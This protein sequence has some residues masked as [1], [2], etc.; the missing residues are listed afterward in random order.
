L[1]LSISIAMSDFKDVLEKVEALHQSLFPEETFKWYWLDEK[2]ERQYTN[3]K[4]AKNQ[5]TFFTVL[6]IGI[7]CLGLLGLITNK[8]VEK[9]KEIGIRKVMGAQLYQIAE[10]L[11]NTTVKQILIATIIGIPLAYFL[12]QKYLEKFSER[13][14]LQW[15]YFTVPVII[16]MMIMLATV[17]SVLWKAAKSNPV[18]ALKYE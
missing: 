17:A 5:I 18:E 16:L 2:I 12:T 8:S 3:E 9:T 11:L 14:T 1:K 6:A 15:W 10:I 13:I 4:M 7:S